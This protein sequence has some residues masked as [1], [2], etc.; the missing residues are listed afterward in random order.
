M[1][2]L[3]ALPL[4]ALL[5]L[6][7]PGCGGDGS[8]AAGDDRQT[9]AP[10]VSEV[11]TFEL[12]SLSFD[13]GGEIPA[14]HSLEGGNTSPPLEWS[15]VPGAAAELVLVVDDPDAPGDEPFVHWLVAGLDPSE[16][17]IEEGTLPE[18]AIEGTNDFGDPGYGGPAP[19]SGTHRYV[20]TMLALDAESGLGEAFDR[21]KLE[22][23]VDGRVV[24]RAELTGTFSAG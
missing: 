19:P 11:E 5:V 24:G 8:G 12:T 9:T 13:D 16:G 22:A 10:E 21:Q 18:G 23:A 20:F 7:V 4:L 6:L 17:S 2:T 15:G 3:L 14:K 1:R